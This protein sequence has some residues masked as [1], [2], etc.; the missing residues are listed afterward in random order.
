MLMVSE[1]RS[2][3]W[4]S[5]LSSDPKYKFYRIYI[6]YPKRENDP[7]VYN[8]G[9]YLFDACPP[10]CS[11]IPS[12]LYI[13]IHIHTKISFHLLT[14]IHSFIIIL[15]Y[16]LQ[17]SNIFNKLLA[18]PLSFSLSL[19]SSLLPWFPPSLPPSPPLSQWVLQTLP[20]LD[21]GL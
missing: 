4:F 9:L 11:P 14:W 12:L 1:P 13:Y 8:Q 2:P 5:P 16:S 6:I 18:C 19:S 10:K 20:H 15:D 17:L 21:L 3:I 7:V